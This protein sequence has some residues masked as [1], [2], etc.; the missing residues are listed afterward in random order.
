MEMSWHPITRSEFK[1]SF[2]FRFI[3][4]MDQKLNEVSEAIIYPCLAKSV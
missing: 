4:N 2:S 1:K 3:I